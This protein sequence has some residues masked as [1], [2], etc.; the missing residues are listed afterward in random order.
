MFITQR[1]QTRLKLLI[2]LVFSCITAIGYAQDSITETLLPVDANRAQGFALF[3]DVETVESRGRPTSRPGRESRATIAEPEFTLAGVSRIADNYTAILRHKSGENYLLKVDSSAN[4]VIPEHTD[5]AV[6]AASAGSVSIQY[7]D[8]ND[9]IEFSERG[10]TCNSAANIAVLVLATGD[11]IVTKNPSTDAALA[12][13]E[14]DGS[15][16]AIEAQ[17]E[18]GNPFEALRNARRAEAIEAAAGASSAG[19]A[20]FTPRRIDPEDV[21]EGKRVVATPFGDRLVDL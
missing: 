20:R 15:G 14:A 8:N 18:P 12:Q 9:C 16:V 6:V 10:V 19:G 1:Y 11:P 3:E 17:T 7:P 21:P 2:A 13:P 4:S 5:Y